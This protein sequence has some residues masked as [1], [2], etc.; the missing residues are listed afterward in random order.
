MPPRTPPGSASGRAAAED[1]P[2]VEVTTRAELRA[3]LGA[4][5]ARST[6]IWLVTRKRT[7]GGELR[8]NDIVEE[9]LAVGW[10]DSLPRKLDE[11]RSMLLLTPRKPKSGWSA[12]NK[13]HIADLERRGLM[14]APG[15]A[16]VEVAKANGSWD[17][18]DGAAAL[19]VPPD[20]A[21]A[22]AAHPPAERQW[23]SFS[24]SARRGILEWIA[25]ARRPE[26]RARRIEETARLASEG[27]RA[28]AWREP[29][30]TK[31]KAGS[32]A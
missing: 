8:W 24:P 30:R 32:N 25:L 16:A 27:R 28:N 1:R 12:K 14:C 29:G 7:A 11:E 13:A 31:P 5:H 20:L 9:A 23:A 6:G 26:T 10:I 17:A 19:V 21:A 4:N 18:L 3:W 15:R 22:F 2:R